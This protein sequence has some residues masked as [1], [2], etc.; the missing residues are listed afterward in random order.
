[1]NFYNEFDPHA[2]AWIGE[3]LAASVLASGTVDSRSVEEVRPS[4]LS[5]FTQAHF[6]AGIGG[7]AHALR[8]AGWGGDR[9]VWTASLPCQPFSVAGK[10]LREADERH[11]WPVFR[12]L[13]RE[14]RPPIIFG[15]QVASAAGR[16][17]LAG[18]RTDLEGMGYA[19]GAADLCAPSVGAPH[20]R[21]RLYWTAIRVA[22]ANQG[23]RGWFADGEG[24]NLDG[25]QAG[26]IKG[27]GEFEPGGEFGGLGDP[28]GNGREPGWTP[29]E[30][31]GHRGSTDSAGGELVGVA[32]ASGTRSETW[33]PEPTE[34][35]KWNTGEFN[36]SGG[37]CF[38]S[39]HRPALD[40]WSDC[41]LI[42]CRDG[43][44][45][46]VGSGIFPLAHGLPRGVVP[47]GDPDSQEA[48]ASQE[49]RKTRLRGYG[50]A[51]VPQLAAEFVRAV[52]DVLEI[53]QGEK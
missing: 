11:L 4:D 13:V 35:E 24:C 42:Q 25:A 43:K 39:G 29:A 9:P 16:L 22:D 41:Y 20:I 15:E 21:Q 10:G 14:C 52:M 6:F 7:W 33:I 3:L 47:S 40:A 48:N 50:N 5:G 51:I 44:I 17:W 53:Q 45:R 2:A 46:R 37:E 38:G 49:G 26:R 34:R 19:V 36:D 8:L 31:A 18:V 1:V 32:D 30:A 12:E 23:Q 28:D 27:D